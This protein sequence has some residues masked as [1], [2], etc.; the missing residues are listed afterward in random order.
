MSVS[1]NSNLEQAPVSSNQTVNPQQ[2]GSLQT[3]NSKPSGTDGIVTIT[4][5]LSNPQSNA[6]V[7][8]PGATS[9]QQLVAADTSSETVPTPTINYVLFVVVMAGLVL[10]GGAMVRRVIK[11]NL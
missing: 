4:Q 10:A 6:L 2:P 9:A 3:N 7:T 11:D 5:L 8:V 1:V